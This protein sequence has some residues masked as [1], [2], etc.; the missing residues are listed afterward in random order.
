M[1]GSMFLLVAS[2]K[3]H[4]RLLTPRNDSPGCCSEHPP[5]SL[6]GVLHR[7]L[8]LEWELEPPPSPPILPDI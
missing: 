7:T 1:P 3:T 8:W 6:S 5:A 4:S 2:M